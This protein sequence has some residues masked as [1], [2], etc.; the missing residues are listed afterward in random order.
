LAHHESLPQ[1]G[2]SP[3]ILKGSASVSA[4]AVSG[5]KAVWFTDL[6]L[7]G[8]F[9][10]HSPARYNAL[11]GAEKEDIGPENTYSWNLNL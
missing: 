4:M 7:Y 11:L 6:E 5:Q 9:E 1:K 3:Q 10:P 8:H 2:I